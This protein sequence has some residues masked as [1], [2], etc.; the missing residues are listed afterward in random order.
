MKH[1]NANLDNTTNIEVPLQSSTRILGLDAFNNVVEI[2]AVTQPDDGDGSGGMGGGDIM[3]GDG[4][5]TTPI[6]PAIGT[7]FCY[8]LGDNTSSATSVFIE[9]INACYEVGNTV[10]ITDPSTTPSSTITTVVTSITPDVIP[11][12][13]APAYNG[14]GADANG[15]SEGDPL[16]YSPFR[17]YYA[18]EV[19]SETT[20]GGGST[21]YG[22]TWID[23]VWEFPNST[24]LFANPNNHTF[25][26]NGVQG[27][28]ND[29]RDLTDYTGGTILYGRFGWDSNSNSQMWNATPNGSTV[30]LFFGGDHGTIVLRKISTLTAH[31]APQV[32]VSTG[33]FS[34]YCVY[35]PF[36]A[37]FNSTYGFTSGNTGSITVGGT[38]TGIGQW[39]PT[40]KADGTRNGIPG[41]LRQNGLADFTNLNDITTNGSQ[42]TTGNGNPSQSGPFAWRFSG[43]TFT[44]NGTIWANDN[45]GSA[46][47]YFSTIS[48]T[49]LGDTISDPNRANFFGAIPDNGYYLNPGS[50]VVLGSF[51]PGGGIGDDATAGGEPETSEVEICVEVVA[52]DTLADPYTFPNTGVMYD[53]N[54]LCQATDDPIDPGDLTD[55]DG[56]LDTRECARKKIGSP[57]GIVVNTITDGMDLL[58]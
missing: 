20:G 3:D 43:G 28:A 22:W 12:A 11:P 37:S 38:A 14:S 17:D 32:W 45:A 57:S 39:F 7:E 36:S 23:W 55:G 48:E 13:S 56:G 53:F 19:V 47:T 50:A 58:L 18:W 35:P 24:G 46:P 1:L 27:P 8:T 25:F 40:V 4:N 26:Y 2:T 54:P 31:P 5:P 51:R 30:T 44:Y 29:G 10:I 52:V 33:G 49:Y 21:G 42:I 34:C 9:D 16:W 41:L 6:D 15:L